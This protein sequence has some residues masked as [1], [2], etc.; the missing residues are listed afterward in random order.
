MNHETFHELIALRLYDEID[1]SDRS[2]LEAHLEICAACRV[3]AAEIEQGL[4]AVARA[5]R[6]EADLPADW[7]E[8]M[9]RATLA[10]PP[11]RRL[12]PW[13]T[14]VAG[15][16]AGVIA[17]IAIARGPAQAPA[18][19]ATISTWERFHRDAPPPAATTEGPFARL[20]EYRKR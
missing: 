5:Q 19:V 13:W 8:R 16:A 11:L 9:R 3:F 17:T 10:S 18:N 1:A 20:G 4:G 14:A 6:T 15:F 2:R 12:T 7:T